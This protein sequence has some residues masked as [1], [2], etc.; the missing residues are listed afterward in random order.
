[1]SDGIV[2]IN[3][4]STSVKFVAYRCGAT[5][6]LDMVCRGRADSIGSDSRLIV[7]SPQGKSMDVEG[8]EGGYPLDVEGMINFLII[9]LETHQKGF[10]IVGVGHRVVH[11][12]LAYHAPVLV[13]D[14]VLAE[15]SKLEVVE[16]SHQA[17]EVDVIRAIAHA[18]PDLRQVAAFDTSFHRTMPALAQRYALPAAIAGELIQHWGFHGISYEYISRT[19]PRYAPATRRVIVAHLGGGASMCALLDGRSMDTSMGFSPLD[20]LPMS[21]R[22]GAIDAGILFYLMKARKFTPAD[23]ESLLY[24]KSGLL[25]VS[26]IS[27]DMRVL[28]DSRVPAA[29]EAIDYFVY[30]IAR[31]AGAYAVVLGGLDAFVFTAGIGENDAALRAAVVNKLAWLGVRL[32][33]DANSRHGPR[34]STEDSKVS[35]WVIPTDE[36]LMIAQ[37]TARLMGQDE[38]FEEHTAGI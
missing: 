38:R 15:L 29:T 20:G 6:A 8:W 11:G 3:V 10:K 17:Q 16:P 36:E 23:L 2:V 1:M 30:H 5:G 31:F 4:G 7:K 27:G 14:V 34:I 12:G 18:R 19:L 24:A 37:H 9:W 26:G 32:D 33:P 13:D 22:C 21:T 25:G 28:R 35:V